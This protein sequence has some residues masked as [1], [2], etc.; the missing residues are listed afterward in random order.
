[1]SGRS[2]VI[3]QGNLHVL[4]SSS[5]FAAAALFAVALLVAAP[6]FADA[7]GQG[8]LTPSA[9][10]MQDNAGFNLGCTANDVRVS[11]VADI[12]GDFVV[13]EDDITFN[14][15]CDATASRPH[16][17]C[18]PPTKRGSVWLEWIRGH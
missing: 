1:M 10:C 5:A 13:D 11:G 16:S 6:A 8:S 7:T 9:P 15:V 12:N 18:V 17:S 3:S 4:L 14:Q 2:K